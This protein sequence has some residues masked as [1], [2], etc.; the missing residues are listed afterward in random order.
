MEGMC[1]FRGG[2]RFPNI[3]R[4]G[5]WFFVLIQKHGWIRR[6]VDAIE[7]IALEFRNTATHC[8]RYVDFGSSVQGGRG[9]VAI[10]SER[11]GKTRVLVATDTRVFGDACQV[12]MCFLYCSRRSRALFSHESSMLVIST[13][14]LRRRA[15]TF[16]SSR[17]ASPQRSKIGN[18]EAVM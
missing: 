15:K 4:E 12:D 11:K 9:R 3:V 5:F 6:G 14:Q 18:I 1:S 10:L 17:N 2:R 8:A 7:L 16:P 13:R